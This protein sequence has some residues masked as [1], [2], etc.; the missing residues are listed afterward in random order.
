MPPS[1]LETLFWLH[2]MCL[3]IEM[4]QPE[5]R[6]HPTRKWRLD[7]AWPSLRI[8]VELEGAVWTGGR[9]TRGGG[10][11]A[12]MEKYNALTSMGWRLLRFDGGAVR[13]GRAAREAAELF[14]ALAADAAKREDDS[15][16]G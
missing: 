12:D 11:L 15:T 8:A 16:T 14:R 9:H 3:D 1:K 13:S 10:F 5:F 2:L 4:P 6:F 7:F